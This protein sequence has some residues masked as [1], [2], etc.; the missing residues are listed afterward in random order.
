MSDFRLGEWVVHPAR[1]R[2]SRS[3]T[4]VQ[5]EPRAMD[6]LIY[7]TE[8][9]GEVVSRQQIIDAV[10][11][12]E[13]VSDGT[14]S[15]TIAK[16][17][18]ALGDDTSSPRYI[19]TI[20]KRGYRLLPPPVDV[21]AVVSRPG[22]AFRVG[23]W[24]VEP[25]LNRLSRGDT[26]VRLDQ[27]T[28]DVLLYLAE[29][30]GEA[31]PRNEIVERIWRTESVSDFAVSR[32]IAELQEAL[33]DAD[34]NPRYIEAVP[35]RGYRLAAV[36][37]AE[38]SAAVMPFPASK[39][40]AERDPYPGLVAFTEADAEFFFGREAETA[41]MWRRISR[42]RL[43]AVIGPS[44]V[45]KSS[46][47]RAG[48]IPCAPPGWRA[49]IFAP[50]AAPFMA[51]ARALVP[52]L[53]GEAEQVEHLLDFDDPEVARAVLSRWRQRWDEALLV[54]D[55]AEELFTLNPPETRARFIDLI[56]S[57]VT[58]VRVHV[59]LVLR[60]DFVC[61]CHAHP[62][63]APIFRDLTVLG[64]P[65]AHD[66]RRALVEPAL[67]NGYRFEDETLSDEMVATL[68]EERGALPLLAFATRRLWQL[69]DEERRLLT[70]ESYE[71]IGGV[72]GALAQHAEQTLEE[73]GQ[74]RLPLVR[75][76]FRNLVTARATRATRS[77][78]EL[79][80]VFDEAE[81][82][83][84]EHVLQ[85]LTD[86]RLLTSFEEEGEEEGRIEGPRRV[87]IVH[88]SLL[89]EWPR[90]VRWQTQDADAARLRDQLR[91]AAQLWHMRGRPAEVT[92]T[93]CCGPARPTS[94]SGP[95]SRA[96]PAV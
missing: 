46:F 86:A 26:S 5:L 62:P 21:L 14:L 20:P 4:Q 51:L 96:T 92:R 94:S 68:A 56:I 90:L 17:R 47:L 85:V 27:S 75:E 12:K 35:E 15:G 10:W 61:E 7:L 52:E 63:L 39:T 29:R 54:I 78:E 44:G 34:P 11:Q 72:G 49:L 42:H 23:E 36:V 1:N 32:S 50:G 83:T 22:G 38:P 45:G 73:I 18:K 58:D 53:A 81:R 74:D 55:Q 57:L 48:V 9:A 25:S 70:R 31:V 13:F 59:V 8:N 80:S 91:Q 43:L 65:A 71:R 84:A 60:D 41:A 82:G 87:E 89:R 67:C 88:E 16:L 40:Q 19:E 95:G 69:R 64:P 24:L 6:L 3:S 37:A 66:L 28:M 2:L 33:G 93:S 76:L 79:L 30:A 77:V